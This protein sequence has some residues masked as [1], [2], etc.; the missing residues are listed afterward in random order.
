MIAT[1]EFF[2]AYGLQ[3]LFVLSA[4]AGFFG[5]CCEVEREAVVPAEMPVPV[6]V[7]EWME[8]RRAA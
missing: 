4:V 3:A 7:A 8:A 1:L 6:A 2:A 5:V